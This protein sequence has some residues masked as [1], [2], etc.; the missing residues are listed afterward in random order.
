MSYRSES[1]YVSSLQRTYLN[2]ISNLICFTTLETITQAD[3]IALPIAKILVA[4][5]GTRLSP[6]TDKISIL[7]P[8]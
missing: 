1:L 8:P 7:N 5:V 3:A 2:V 6:P 4:S